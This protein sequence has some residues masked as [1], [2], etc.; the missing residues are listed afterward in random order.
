MLHLLHPRHLRQH[1]PLFQLQNP[2]C[3]RQILQLS[4]MVAF[5]KNLVTVPATTNLSLRRQ[6][7][8]S[9]LQAMSVPK[10]HS[11]CASTAEK[12]VALLPVQQRLQHQNRLLSLISVLAWSTETTQAAVSL[13]TAATLSTFPGLSSI[14][15]PPAARPPMPKPCP[16]P[17]SPTPTLFDVT[18]STAL[19]PACILV[20]L[21]SIVKRP[22]AWI[23]SPPA[24]TTTN[25]AVT[26]QTMTNVPRTRS[27]CSPIAKRPAPS[28]K[29]SPSTVSPKSF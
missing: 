7:V 23:P 20:G 6:S 14:A 18:K 5:L 27:I 21:S 13:P 12:A 19:L 22:V 4:L 25:I 15:L 29:F 28:V 3:S 16:V 26:G 2:L 10:T 17:T 11:S 9:G 24:R 1:R 8:N